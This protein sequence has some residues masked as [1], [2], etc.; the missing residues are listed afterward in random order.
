MLDY[1]GY[2]EI[3]A[4]Y[5][6]SRKYL[7]EN[8]RFTSMDKLLEY[9]QDHSVDVLLLGQEV[10]LQRLPSG[11]ETGKVIVLSEGNLVGENDVPVIF[12]YQSAEK[13][14]QEIFALL[15]EKTDYPDFQPVQ[16]SK[17]SLSVFILLPVFWKGFGR[18]FMPIVPATV[19]LQEH[20]WST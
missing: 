1:Q 17:R 5:L 13:I 6:D 12:K 2:M 20:F 7:L 18:N 3:L 11:P 8:R 9:L 10:E 16:E 14:L 15:A 4:R 19:L